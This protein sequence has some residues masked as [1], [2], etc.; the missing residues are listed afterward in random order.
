VGSSEGKKDIKSIDLEEKE[1]GGESLTR[2][3]ACSGGKRSKSVQSIDER[4]KKKKNMG[5]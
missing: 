3:K 1:R 4:E 2:G 5:H